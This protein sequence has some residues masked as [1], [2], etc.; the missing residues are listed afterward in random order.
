MPFLESAAF[1]AVL[2]QAS[3]WVQ[4]AAAQAAD[5]EAK[6]AAQL[7]YSSGV[8]VAALRTLDN[9]FRRVVGVVSQLD[10][11][12]PDERRQAAVK[13][14]LEIAHSDVVLPE[15]QDA[16]GYLRTAVSDLAE[17]ERAHAQRILTAGE[18]VVGF[19]AKAPGQTPFQTKEQLTT[20]LNGIAHANTPQWVD[21]TI[22]LC[23]KALYIFDRGSL[24]ELTVEL[25]E[26]KS[27]LLRRH[28]SIAPAP[29]WTLAA[30]TV[31]QAAG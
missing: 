14:I 10:A 18:T 20:L 11:T 16:V 28:P 12:W 7:L 31:P 15:L 29:R 25:G 5:N 4:R 6:L 2:T 13:S 19:M 1:G 3:S 27:A 30:A 26:L 9:G 8:A 17:P 24:G 22:E 21:R 23:E